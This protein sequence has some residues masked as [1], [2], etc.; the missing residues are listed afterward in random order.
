MK[1]FFHGTNTSNTPNAVYQY[2]GE[3]RRVRKVSGNRLTIFV[4]NSSGTLIAEYDSQ[5]ATNY[6]KFIL[7]QII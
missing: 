1:E 3:G 6:R 4:Y 2:D 7:R 5:L